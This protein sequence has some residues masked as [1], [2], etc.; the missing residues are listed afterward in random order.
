M[1]C[2]CPWWGEA[3]FGADRLLVLAQLVDHGWLDTDHALELAAFAP[4]KQGLSRLVAAIDQVRLDW[5]TGSQ[6]H[7]RVGLRL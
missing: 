7:V 5:K 3:G 2:R 1:A 6:G 4:G